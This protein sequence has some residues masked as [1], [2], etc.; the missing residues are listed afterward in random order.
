[1]RVQFNTQ[2][3]SLRFADISFSRFYECNLSTGVLYQLTLLIGPLADAMPRICCCSNGL[4]PRIG[5]NRA[6]A[7][8]DDRCI[9]AAD[10]D[11]NRTAL[12]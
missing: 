9:A 4:P 10:A 3:C 6:E 2:S 1:M 5:D 8:K 12:G 7:A 11:A